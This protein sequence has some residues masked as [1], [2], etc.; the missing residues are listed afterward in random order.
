VKDTREQF[1]QFGQMAFAFIR[2]PTCLSNII[3]QTFKIVDAVTLRS[4]ARWFSPNEIY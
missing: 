1:S 3:R 2:H 4:I